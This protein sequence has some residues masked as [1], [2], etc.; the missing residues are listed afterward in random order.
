MEVDGMLADVVLL[1]FYGFILS[2]RGTKEHTATG[3]GGFTKTLHF[4]AMTW[5]TISTL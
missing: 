2:Q 1:L 4:Y 5:Y 3:R